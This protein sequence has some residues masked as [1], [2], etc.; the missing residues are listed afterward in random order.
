MFTKTMENAKNWSR[1]SDNISF[2]N[3]RLSQSLVSGR[4]AIGSPSVEQSEKGNISPNVQS[5]IEDMAQMFPV[6]INQII[7]MEDGNEPGGSA[8]IERLTIEG[9][10]DFGSLYVYGIPVKT[11][12]GDNRATITQK[13]FDALQIQQG[14]NKLFKSVTKV[15]GQENQLDVEFLDT[16]VHDNFSTSAN[17]IVITGETLQAAVPGYGTWTR[18]GSVDIKND[19]NKITKAYYFKRIL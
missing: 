12:P 15:T 6:S 10:A 17:E 18:L 19:D 14:N 9:S 1:E 2:D 11:T 4:Q 3:S 5:A 7:L 13:V 16:K 8:M